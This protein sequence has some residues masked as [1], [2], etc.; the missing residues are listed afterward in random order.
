[1]GIIDRRTVSVL[2]TI[3]LFA[4]AGV[5]VYSARS[6][7]IAFLFAIFFAYLLDPAV[8]L[9]ASKL[10]RGSRGRAILLIYLC[11]LA[12]LVLWGFLVG[13]RL[14]SEG[15]SLATA[16]PG[17]LDKVESGQIAHQIGSRRGWSFNTQARVA[18]FLASHQQAII[19]SAS[20]AGK[21]VASVAGHIIWIILIPI[22]AVFFLRDGR[23]LSES[24]IRTVDQRGQRQFL[25]GLSEDM[26]GMLAAYI[27]AQLTLAIVSLVAYIVVLEILRVPYAIVL[28]TLGG[29]MEFVPVV[30]PAVAALMILGVGVLT[31]YQHMLI[32]V[33][34]LVG[35]RLVQDY[36]ASPRIMG[37]KLEL[38]PLAAL[39][40]VLV[41]GEIGGVVGVYLSIPIMA[42]LRI[43]WR[44]YQRYS[45]QQKTRSDVRAA[46]DIRA[47]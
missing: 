13:P 19:D 43:F 22:L 44:R 7:L 27:R 38:H 29:I 3:L 37:S 5:L 23:S 39:F 8:S 12:L 25:R 47:A 24:A 20:S 9:I 10:T 2:L 21:K 46:S 32:L 40:A 35:W 42:T 17:L 36:V 14:A 33:L 45:E 6:T 18:Q 28:G 4:A 15:R 26:N 41:G 16:L 1:V 34:F 30:G 31:S 11:L